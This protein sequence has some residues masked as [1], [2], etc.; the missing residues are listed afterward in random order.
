MNIRDLG[1]LPNNVQQGLRSRSLIARKM[2]TAVREHIGQP[3]NALRQNNQ[4]AANLA[5]ENEYDN[6]CKARF[7]A[8]TDQGE[9]VRLSVDKFR[10]DYTLK[11]S[12]PSEKFPDK[13]INELLT[14]K[15]TRAGQPMH[16]M[17]YKNPD[18][19]VR[20]NLSFA[21]TA[22]HNFNHTRVVNLSGVNAAF[23][24]EDPRNYI[25][26]PALESNFPF[27]SRTTF[28]PSNKANNYINNVLNFEAMDAVDIDTY[29]DND[30]MEEFVNSINDNSPQK[31]KD[32]KAQYEIIR[33]LQENKDQIFDG[34]VELASRACREKPHDADANLLRDLSV[35]G[36]RVEVH[37]QGDGDTYNVEFYDTEGKIKMAGSLTMLKDD[38]GFPLKEDKEGNIYDIIHDAYYLERHPEDKM[39][40]DIDLQLYHDGIE[41]PALSFN[42]QVV[43]LE[44]GKKVHRM[45]ISTYDRNGDIIN[46]VEASMPKYSEKWLKG[47]MCKVAHNTFKTDLKQAQGNFMGDMLNHSDLPQEMDIE[48]RPEL[49]FFHNLPRA[50]GLRH[51]LN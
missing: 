17:Y 44:N 5:V 18:P 3:G 34:P 40:F 45:T 16:Y 30:L 33:C 38:R 20:E 32:F 15:G 46:Q 24:I 9:E 21:M 12:A 31:E 10:N 43:T 2:A 29:I 50:I 35:N 7:K 47:R 37:T 6:N 39:C 26:L 25:P 49:N 51:R 28:V 27:K 48:N 22:N 4:L 36:D 1:N 23:N 41:Q 14:N 19:R 8:T 13:N 42:R 11:Y